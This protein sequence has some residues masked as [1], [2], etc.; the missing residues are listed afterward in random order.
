MAYGKYS[1]M[2]SFKPW[3]FA[4]WKEGTQGRVEV[5]AE[6]FDRYGYDENGEDCIGRTEEDYLIQS[7]EDSRYDD[8]YEIDDGC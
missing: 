2:V 4:E 3:V 5:N 8:M 7:M 6:G 1:P